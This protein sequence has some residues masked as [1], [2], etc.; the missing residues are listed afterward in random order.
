MTNVSPL[1][2]RDEDDREWHGRAACRGL[3]TDPFFQPADE[4]SA[5]RA[6]REEAARQVCAPC[7]VRVECRRHALNSREPYGVWGGLTE[8]DRRAL[9]A[10]A[11]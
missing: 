8:E 1:P 6:V 11:G 4:S 2:G 7:P 5:E 3:G 9:Y 10:R